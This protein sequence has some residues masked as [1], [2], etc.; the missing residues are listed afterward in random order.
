[1]NNNILS[2]LGLALRGGRLAIGDEPV[3]LAAKAGQAR[4]LLTASDAA[5]NTLRHTEHLAQEGRC[6]WLVLPFTKAELGG[7]L[8][9]GGTAVAALTDTGLAAAVTARL[10]ALDPERYGDIAARMDLKL[11]RA[12]ERRAAPHRDPPVQR[13]DRRTSTP[14]RE[15]SR[16]QSAGGRQRPDGQRGDRPRTRPWGGDQKHSSTAANRSYG[17]KTEE[18]RSQK[19]RGRKSHDSKGPARGHP[20]GRKPE[21]L[22]PGHSPRKQTDPG[23]QSGRGHGRGG[24]R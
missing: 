10:A 3:A 18:G 14:R 6:L 22:F 13:E 16:S 19:G 12:K 23:F 5:G 4:L 9:R 21:R 2:L 7:A 1:M 11:R 8:G 24:G 20:Q 17:A 15:G